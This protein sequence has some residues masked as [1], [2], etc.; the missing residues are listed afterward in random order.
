MDCP[1]ELL[2]ASRTHICAVFQFK[3]T[4]GVS[5][6]GIRTMRTHLRQPVCRRKA[7]TIAH[8]VSAITAIQQARNRYCAS[9]LPNR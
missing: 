2:K 8:A 6:D 9:P 3:A 4:V 7:T 5:P 1:A